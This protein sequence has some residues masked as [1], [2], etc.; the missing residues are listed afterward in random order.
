MDELVFSTMVL[1]VWL[2]GIV[3][4]LITT[5]EHILFGDA[6]AND[7]EISHL[8][9]I[10]CTVCIGNVIITVVCKIGL[11]VRL[12]TIIGEPYCSASVV[13]KGST[14]PGAG[15]GDVAMSPL[16]ICPERGASDPVSVVT[17]VANALTHDIDLVV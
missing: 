10:E 2:A 7:D 5:S 3:V 4:A 8:S 1:V 13:V 17:G 11:G 6:I 14:V 12:S 15:K 9:S 16:V